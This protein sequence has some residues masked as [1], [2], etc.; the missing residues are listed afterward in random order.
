MD[1]IIVWNDSYSVGHD[2]LDSQHKKLVDIINSLSIEAEKETAEAVE[3]LLNSLAQYTVYHF[4]YEESLFE[5][6][7]FPETQE[8]K[9]THREFINRV[10]MWREIFESGKEIDLEA[11]ASYLRK[12]LI[13]HIC[14][15]DKQMVAWMDGVPEQ[16][17]A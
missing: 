11:I 6:A 1:N 13:G 3:F 2:D 16:K 4:T 12:W 15:I 10:L 8:H 5:Q 7:G 9:R 14:I 17:K